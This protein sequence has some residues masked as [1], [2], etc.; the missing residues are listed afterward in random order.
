MKLMG[1]LLLAFLEQGHHVALPKNVYFNDEPFLG[2]PE[3]A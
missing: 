3:F 1:L 2:C